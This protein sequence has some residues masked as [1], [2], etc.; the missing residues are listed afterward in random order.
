MPFCAVMLLC[1]V[2]IGYY[3]WR[4]TG[5]P[6]LFPYALN[7]R[8]YVTTPTLFW[9]KERPPIHFLNP[10]FEAFYNVEAREQWLEGRVNSFGKAVK[11]LS[12]VGA[13]SVYFYFW[14]ELC[15]PLLFLPCVLLDRR[16]RFLVLQTGISAL[17]LLL[18]PWEESRYVAPLTATLFVLLVQA[19]RHLRQWQPNGRP[20]GIAVS[21]VTFLFVLLLAPFRQ[22]ARYLGHA[23]PEG[24]EFRA[25]F[26]SQLNAAP[27]DHLVI[28]R[29]L[30]AHDVDLEW[31]YNAADI[32]HSKVIWAR[33]IPGLDIHPL[34]DYFRGRRFWLAEPDAIPPRLT[35][36]PGSATH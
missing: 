36:Y 18:V 14:P 35:P 10:Q 9:Q 19:I 23:A 17:G 29:Y 6:L 24:I 31:V 16:V 34:L 28:V 13:R 3:N 27:G 8:T 1:L 20:V 32:D 22:H 4:G 15:V 5:S 11:H 21:R 25:Q 30:P 12:W 33:E 26:A 7:E 2:F